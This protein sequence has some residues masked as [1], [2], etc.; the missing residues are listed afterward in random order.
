M[1]AGVPVPEMDDIIEKL[2]ATG[3]IETA[4]TL[5]ALANEMGVDEGVFTEEMA[6]YDGYCALGVDEAY[7]KAAEKLIALG[8]GPYY[9]IKGYSHSFCSCGGLDINENFEVLK[10]DGETAI[11]GLYAVGNESGGVLYTNKKPYVTYGGAALGW[12]YTSGRLAGR[13]AAS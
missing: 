6:R 2:V 7:G 1:P 10:A 4:D 11:G 9:A 3:Q 12:A 8:E 5:S 13:Y